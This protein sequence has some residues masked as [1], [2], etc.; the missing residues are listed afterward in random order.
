VPP[1][2]FRVTVPRKLRWVALGA[3]LL[4]CERKSSAPGGEVTTFQGSC[5]ASGAVALDEQR[6]LAIDDEDDRV[7]IYHAE[8]GGKP[9]RT[10]TFSPP[11]PKGE[12]K[13]PEADL[14]GVARLGDEIYFLAS[15]AR[16]RSGKLDLHR[17]LFFATGL[18]QSGD[19]LRLIGEPYQR[20]LEDMIASPALARFDLRAAAER[21]PADPGGLNCEGLAAAADGTLLLGFR[22]PRPQGKAILVRLVN[23]REVIRGQSARFDDA[24]LLELGGLGIAALAPFRGGHLLLAGPVAEAAPFRLYNLPAES[25]PTA[26]AA[27]DL[28]DLSPEGLFVPPTQRRV[29]VLSDDGRALRHGKRCKKAD[30]SQKS[31][32]G[33]W[34][35]PPG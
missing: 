34:L 9:L 7:R 10:L 26:V 27:A 2:A 23:P 31:F 20:L 35:E 22:N 12:G 24:R 28:S 6:F 21:G 29:L 13:R 17:R 33:K 16:R 18:P 15:H 14:E 1:Y 25:G 30:A 8:L 32:R 3:A 19:E 11:L 4:C 5:D